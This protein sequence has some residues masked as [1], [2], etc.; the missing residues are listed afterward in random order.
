MKKLTLFLLFAALLTAFTSCKKDSV[1]S[2]PEYSYVMAVNAAA[3]TSGSSIS[4]A[5]GTQSINDIAFGSNSLYTMVNAGNNPVVVA[6]NGNGTS[7]MMDFVAGKSYSLFTVDDLSGLKAVAVE[8]ILPGNTIGI[9]NVRF[10]QFS[11]DAPAMDIVINGEIIFGNRSYNDQVN[12]PSFAAF[13]TILPGTYDIEVRD[14]ATSNVLYTF[15]GVTI[16]ESKTYSII[17]KGS[18]NGINDQGFGIQLVTN[19]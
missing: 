10:F 14:P 13:T 12:D 17:A 7:S 19:N 4:V 6:S 2:G 9:T 11:P 3:S 5:V 18:V 15:Y 8:D 16:D 1:V